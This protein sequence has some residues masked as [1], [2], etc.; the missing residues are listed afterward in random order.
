MIPAFPLSFTH[1]FNLLL[2]PARR[3]SAAFARTP[4]VPAATAAVAVPAIGSLAPGFRHLGRFPGRSAAFRAR[5][6][7]TWFL[8]RAALV[9]TAFFG[10]HQ[11]PAGFEN[12]RGF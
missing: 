6:F 5:P 9:R 11:N 1:W 12:P 4:A 8:L 3:L 10:A 2:R 7:T